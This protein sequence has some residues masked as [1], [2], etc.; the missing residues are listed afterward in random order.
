MTLTLLQVLADDSASAA[1]RAA[2]DA[3][4][5]AAIES[6][7]V[8]IAERDLAAASRPSTDGSTARPSPTSPTAGCAA[9]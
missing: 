2:V 1:A 3:V 7:Q 5:R 8:D 9:T 4:L 6:L